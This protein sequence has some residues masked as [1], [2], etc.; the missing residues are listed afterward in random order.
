M[1]K[2]KTLASTAFY[3]KC[4]APFV[5]VFLEGKL[6]V[7]YEVSRRKGYF[8]KRLREKSQSQKGLLGK[9]PVWEVSEVSNV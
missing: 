4:I 5:N 9:P 3:R 8:K 7:V 6:K 1:E 2:E